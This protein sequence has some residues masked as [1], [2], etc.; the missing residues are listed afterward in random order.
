MSSWHLAWQPL[1]SV[2]ECV[3][4]CVNL[5]SVVKHIER[6]I[7]D[8]ESKSSTCNTDDIHSGLRHISLACTSHIKTCTVFHLLKVIDNNVLH[9]LKPCH[10]T[11]IFNH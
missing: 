1:P 10:N 4:E 6:S 11:D 9:S 5:T 3:C 2:Y 7:Y 8:W